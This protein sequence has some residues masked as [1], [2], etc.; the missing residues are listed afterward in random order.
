LDKERNLRLFIPTHQNRT[1]AGFE[2]MGNTDEQEK[3]SGWFSRGAAGGLRCDLHSCKEE[4]NMKTAKRIFFIL[5]VVCGAL[6]VVFDIVA[7]CMQ[8]QVSGEKLLTM[9]SHWGYI[10]AVNYR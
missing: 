5:T 2:R 6:A 8:V 4:E 1:E 3:G 9:D 10:L 7:V